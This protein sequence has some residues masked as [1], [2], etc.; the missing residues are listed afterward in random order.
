[1]VGPGH[2]RSVQFSGSRF[3][4]EIVPALSEIQEQGCVRLVDLLFINKD[5]TGE[6]T[7]LEN[8]RSG[9]RRRVCLSTAVR[10][11]PLPLTAEDVATA[12]AGLPET[13]RR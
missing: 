8:H 9:Q 12:A 4:G 1:M 2:T 6:L 3:A 5:E 7:L 10:W 11:F 13:R